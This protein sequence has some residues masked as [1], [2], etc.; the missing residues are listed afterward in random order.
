MKISALGELVFPNRHIPSPY[1][2]AKPSR[3]RVKASGRI[4]ADK[5]EVENRQLLLNPR[6]SHTLPEAG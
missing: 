6:F 1:D 5:W 2:T 4:F 3:R